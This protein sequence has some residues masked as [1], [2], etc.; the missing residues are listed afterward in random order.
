[1]F[2]TLQIVENSIVYIVK[3]KLL[4]VKFL[5]SSLYEVPCYRK[6]IDVE[7][8]KWKVNEARKERKKKYERKEDGKTK[9]REKRV[10]REKEKRGRLCSVIIL[11]D[12]SLTDCKTI[13]LLLYSLSA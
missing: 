6:E 12:L 2:N 1:M 8:K 3:P 10:K 13:A 11:L 5:S 7:A 9:G 4:I